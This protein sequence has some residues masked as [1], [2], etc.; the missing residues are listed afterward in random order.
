MKRCVF[1]MVCLVSNASFADEHEMFVQQSQAA[2]I[3]FSA[4]LKGSLMAAMQSGGPVEA[5]NACNRMA[6]V[7]ASDLS[8]KYGLEIARTSLKIRNPK[9]QP[10]ALEKEVLNQFEIRKQQGES[11]ATLSFDES[12]TR[13]NRHEM[14]MMKAIP[15]GELCL[16]CHGTNIPEPVQTKLDQLYPEDQATGFELGD[17]RGAFTIRKIVA[18]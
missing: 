10:S 18:Y 14:F 13:G 12:M 4:A 17:I 6:P 15:T 9:N 2:I 7:I 3:E 5:I 8:K 16:T 11:I 1:V